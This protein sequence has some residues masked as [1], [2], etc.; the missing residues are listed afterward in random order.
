MEDRAFLI[1]IC[2]TMFRSNTTFDFIKYYYGSNW[3]VKFWF[4]LPYRIYNRLMFRFLKKEPLRHNLIKKLRGKT[5][6]QLTLMA[7]DFCKNFLFAKE[8]VQIINII[9][10]KRAEC[11]RLVIASAT[12]DVIANAVAA[13]YNIPEYFSTTLEYDSNGVCTGHISKDL[14]SCKKAMLKAAG[15]VPPYAGVLTDNFSDCD[16]ICESSEA[17]LVTYKMK[18]NKWAEMAL[19]NKF[20][21]CRVVEFI[22]V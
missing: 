11:C 19:I 1:D 10:K 4:S 8:N 22:E 17:Y 16:I 2:G 13:Y 14:L 3:L 7:K 5:C 21:S 9:N 6:E 12:L 20:K 18:K 15:V